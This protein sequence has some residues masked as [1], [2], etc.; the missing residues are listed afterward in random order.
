MR[1]TERWPIH[2]PPRRGER[3]S[4][5][6]YRTATVYQLTVVELLEH[7][8]GARPE[9]A[10]IL[11]VDPPAELVTAIARRSGLD[12]GRVWRMSVAGHIPWLLD[13]LDPHANDFDTYVRQLS[14]LLPTHRRGSGARRRPGPGWRPWLPTEPAVMRA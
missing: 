9:V 5:W 12:H 2:P 4:S 6:L 1:P 8:L 13:S 10:G 14:I 3:L 11:D 7:D